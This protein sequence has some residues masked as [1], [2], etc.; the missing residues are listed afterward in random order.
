MP[1]YN[2]LVDYFSDPKSKN[3][4]SDI[5]IGKINGDENAKISEMYG[6]DQYPTLVFFA[7]DSSSFPFVYPFK[8]KFSD[9]HKFVEIHAVKQTS[10]SQEIDP[11]K[12]E[13][14]CKQIAKKKVDEALDLYQKELTSQG[15]LINA[16]KKK[17]FA[18]LETKVEELVSKVSEI[19]SGHGEK[20]NEE[21]T[22]LKEE[23]ERLKKEDH[24]T[25]E[26]QQ[27]AT[28]LIEAEKKLREKLL[29]DNT[30][31]FEQILA[32][33]QN[34]LDD[35][36]ATMNE[37]DLVKMKQENQ[38]RNSQSPDKNHQTEAIEEENHQ[39]AKVSDGSSSGECNDSF[40]FS[41]IAKYFI[42]F[43]AGI[44]CMALYQRLNSLDGIVKVIKDI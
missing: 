29:E 3:Y 14:S 9:M 32:G 19:H 2:Q 35:I 15:L 37:H 36:Q 20:E 4:R 10:E 31:K 16:S 8:H 38:P 27:S 5:V 41:W 6:V 28:E 22:K 25:Q 18:D 33:V 23:L 39:E 13:E 43:L 34:K 12:L 21:T 7:P 44:S 26:K 1:H 17:Y 24:K 11:A 30:K 42:T 40:A